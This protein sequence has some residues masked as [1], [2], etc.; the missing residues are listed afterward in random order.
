M[1]NNYSI[2]DLAD[3]YFIKVN[4]GSIKRHSC[5]VIVYFEHIQHI[6]LV[7]LLLT[8]HK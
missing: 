5:I 8:L 1:V 6:F 3:I 7:F 2:H 4:S